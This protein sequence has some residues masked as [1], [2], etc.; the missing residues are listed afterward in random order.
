MERIKEKVRAV[1]LK[2]GIFRLSHIQ[3]TFG[4]GR[5]I[6]VVVLE[7]LDSIGFTKRIDEGRILKK[8]DDKF[9][10][11]KDAIQYEKEV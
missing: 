1:I 3:E 11:S 7:Y 4:Y 2:D 8:K 5:L 6:G 10:P 9:Y